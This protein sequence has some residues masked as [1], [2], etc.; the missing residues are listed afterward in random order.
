MSWRFPLPATHDGILMGN[1]LFGVCVWGSDALSLSLNRA[2]FWDRRNQRRVT[3]KMNHASLRAAWKD[4]SEEGIAQLVDPADP[5]IPLPGPTG[6]PMGR[7]DLALRVDSA[8]LRMADGV[9]Q[10]DAGDGRTS[11]RLVVAP[12]RPL[13]LVETRSLDFE[14]VRRPAWDFL[15]DHLQSIGHQPPQMF[16]EA[17]VA[18]WLQPL[19]DDPC[20][21]LACA[22]LDGGLAITAVYGADAEAAR[23]SA[24]ALLG[25]VEAEGMGATI[26]STQAWWRDYWEKIPRVQL[27]VP[28]DEAVYYYGLFKLAAM[29]KEHAALLQGPW[30]EAYQMPDCGNDFH[31]NVNVQMCYW[32]VYAA[33]CPQLLRPLIDKL[34]A[35]EPL[36]RHNA[37]MLFGVE[38]GLFLPM[39]VSDVGEW[40]GHF[41]PSFTDYAT[42]GWVAQLLWLH[43]R[44]SMDTGFLRQT[45]YPFMKGAMRVYEAVLQEEDGRMVMPMGTSPEYNWWAGFEAAGR[46]PSFQLACVHFLLESLIAAAEVLDEDPEEAA[47]WRRMKA[48]V[49]PYV[50]FTQPESARSP[51]SPSGD[52]AERPRLA[53]FEG[54]DLAISHRHHSHLAALHPFD[55]LDPQEEAFARVLRPTIHHWLEVGPG[56]WIAFSFVWAAIIHARLK[57]PEAAYLNYRLW[58]RLFTNRSRGAVELARIGGLTTWTADEASSPMQMDAAMGAINAIQEML[59]HT[60]RGT[61]TVFPAVPGAW[62]EAVCFERMRAEGAFLV[63]ARMTDGR[64]R[65]VEIFSERGAVLRLANN[66]AE[67]LVVRRGAT[68]ERTTAARLTLQTKPGETLTIHPAADP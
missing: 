66:I 49:P 11:L 42:T 23:A 36:M 53:I 37:R 21:C 61:L 2:D 22:R 16:E 41:W 43:Y 35:W 57:D 55:T 50:T 19:P 26:R 40:G 15:G 29:A 63:S 10:L 34:E 33:N 52:I 5:A 20:L 28:E 32:P 31:F 58:H 44:Y 46:N 27:P 45:A 51:W 17:G 56:N 9:L 6:L 39:S 67:A 59:L 14:I 48:K 62:E 64:I 12:C 1:G 54:Q 3:A 18:G 4:R 30:V 38:D 7:I 68:A 8:S 13:L 65:E 25:S 24:I 47:A 60:A